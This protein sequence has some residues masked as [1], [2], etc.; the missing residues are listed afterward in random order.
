MV[1]VVPNGKAAAKLWAAHFL[2]EVKADSTVRR[3]LDGNGF[4]GDKVAP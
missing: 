2:D 4:T 3:A 1:V